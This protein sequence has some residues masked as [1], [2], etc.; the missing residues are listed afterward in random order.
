MN[1]QNSL[2]NGLSGGGDQVAPTTQPW[3]D[4]I[5]RGLWW[6]GAGSIIGITLLTVC[7]S[8]G[9]YFL[10]RPIPGTIELVQLMLLLAAFSGMVIVTASEKN[11]VIRILT[12]RFPQR[13]QRIL[14]SIMNF[15]AF[16]VF[17]LVSWQLWLSAAGWMESGRFTGVLDIPLAPFKFVAAVGAGLVCVMFLRSFI[18]SLGKWRK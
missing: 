2:G 17:A 7:A 5:C 10:D 1:R 11:V 14:N 3:V 9:R 16:G 8:F 18:L 12:S 15:I 13:V 6:V 4:Y